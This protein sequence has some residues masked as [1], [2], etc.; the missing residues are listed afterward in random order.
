MPIV[1][2]AKAASVSGS[3]FEPVY[4]RSSADW[5]FTC[6]ASAVGIDASAEAMDT[7]GATEDGGTAL[8]GVA[9]VGAGDD[10]AVVAGFVVVVTSGIGTPGVVAA[11]VVVVV[12]A[13]A[14]VVT[15]GGVTVTDAD[16]SL[17]EPTV[18]SPVS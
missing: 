16:A 17:F 1:I 6:G 3:E 14:V 7:T 8:V 18:G 10:G 13:I 15:P 9:I 11:I 12:A 4:P 5:P 2:R